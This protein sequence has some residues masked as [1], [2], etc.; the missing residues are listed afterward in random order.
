MEGRSEPIIASCYAPE[1]LEFVKYAL[2][3]V[4]L[5]VGPRGEADRASAEEH[6][7]DIGSSTALG[8][9]RP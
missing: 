4:G 5:V 8:N 6:W 7:R 2:E 1:V 3:E 9:F